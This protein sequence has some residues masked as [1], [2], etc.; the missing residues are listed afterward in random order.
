[1]REQ[2]R[3]GSPT[4]ASYLYENAPT[5]ARDTPCLTHGR[6]AHTHARWTT[7]PTS[8]PRYADFEAIA[9]SHH[10]DWRINCED[11]AFG[12]DAAATSPASTPSSIPG[13]A[14]TTDCCAPTSPTPTSTHPR[15][16]VPEHALVCL[17]VADQHRLGA[18]HPA[19]GP[20][21]ASIYGDGTAQRRLPWRDWAF[22]MIRGP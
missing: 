17:R 16:L 9:R 20:T 5:S 13:P 8:T 4:L 14:T 6:S 22:T 15:A 2:P 12:W 19:G 10:E 18:D 1:M 7:L 11:W 21:A 3:R